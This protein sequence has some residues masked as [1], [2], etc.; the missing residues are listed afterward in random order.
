MK[1]RAISDESD[2]GRV[3][4]RG[5]MFFI[6]GDFFCL[7]RFRERKREGG[8]ECVEW[9]VIDGVCCRPTPGRSCRTIVEE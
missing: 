4:E 1:V 2:L 9:V 8:G 6:F 5:E 7:S 3:L